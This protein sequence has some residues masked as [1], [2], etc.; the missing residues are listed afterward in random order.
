ML[1]N[2]SEISEGLYAKLDLDNHKIE[3][4]RYKFNQ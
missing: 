4:Y 3:I 2:F 1:M